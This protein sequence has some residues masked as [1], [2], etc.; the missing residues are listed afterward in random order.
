M[1]E[2]EE[3]PLLRTWHIPYTTSLCSCGCTFEFETDLMKHIDKY[4]PEED[5]E[6]QLDLFSLEV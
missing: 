5:K 6:K 1:R 2:Y 4:L 3:A